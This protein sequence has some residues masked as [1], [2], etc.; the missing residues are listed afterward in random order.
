[1]LISTLI[2]QVSSLI[3]QDYQEIKQ[4]QFDKLISDYLQTAPTNDNPTLYHMFGIPSAGKTTF[5][6]SHHW[7]QHVLVSFD[8]IMEDLPAYQEDV[9]KTDPVTAFQKWELTA[10]IIGYELLRQ[11]V[12]ER[13]NIFF[14]HGGS[15]PAHLDLLKNLHHLGYNIE[16]C[17]IYCDM[18][19]ALKRA[20][21][22]EKQTHRHTPPQMIQHRNEM[23]AKLIDEYKKAADVFYAYNSTSDGFI[24]NKALS[25]APQPPKS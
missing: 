15:F 23:I 3:P 16:V 25:S 7:P 2:P 6:S 13:K 18:N 4:P 10:R 24:F 8:A 21:E 9:K 1:M 22:R 17:Y 20:K 19:E 11:A 5:Y 12:Q 14:D